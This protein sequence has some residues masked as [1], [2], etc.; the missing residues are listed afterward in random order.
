MLTKNTSGYRVMLILNFNFSALYSDFDLGSH[1]LI[2]A[3]Q[4]LN[5]AP[6]M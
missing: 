3:L 2:D 6:E 5:T 1:T 4:H